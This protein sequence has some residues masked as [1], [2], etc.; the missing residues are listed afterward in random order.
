MGRTLLEPRFLTGL[1]VAL[2]LGVTAAGCSRQTIESH[3]EDFRDAREHA[4]DNVGVA[5]ETARDRTEDVKSRIPEVRERMHETF[6]VMKEGA[7]RFRERLPSEEQM[8]ERYERVREGAERIR[9]TLPSREAV[10]AVV[11]ETTDSV[12]EA[13]RAASESA[14]ERIRDARAA[15][16]D[17]M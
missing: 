6:E 8:Q 1:G 9:E 15:L 4:R 2:G 10:G 3:I 13:T 16:R 7:E 12:R 11:S 14:Q 17:R 5:V